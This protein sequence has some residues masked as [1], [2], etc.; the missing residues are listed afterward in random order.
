MT[1]HHIYYE[2]DGSSVGHHETMSTNFQEIEK[3]TL[4]KNT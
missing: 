4:Q 3:C 2:I 1:G